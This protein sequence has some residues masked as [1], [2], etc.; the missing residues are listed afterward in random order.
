MVIDIDL[1]VMTEAGCNV[2]NAMMISINGDV[3]RLVSWLVLV[4]VVAMD[5]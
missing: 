5:W 1:R 3:F 4:L 2:A